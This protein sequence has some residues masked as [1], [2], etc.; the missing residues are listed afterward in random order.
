M[1]SDTVVLTD[2]NVIANLKKW[3]KDEIKTNEIKKG[4]IKYLAEKCNT[5]KGKQFIADTCNT[6]ANEYNNKTVQH[7]LNMKVIKKYQDNLNHATNGSNKIYKG[8]D[9]L[10]VKCVKGSKV[11]T[12]EIKP[13]VDY[14]AQ[15]VNRITNIGKGEMTAKQINECIKHLESLLVVDAVVNG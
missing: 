11:Y 10:T 12:I 6:L 9:T 13:N 8:K 14:M 7:D 5:E 1:K 2:D 15:F 3:V 4:F